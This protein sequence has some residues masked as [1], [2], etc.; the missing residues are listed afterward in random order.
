MILYREI[1]YNYHKIYA[2][3]ILDKFVEAIEGIDI[4]D[5]NDPNWNTKDFGFV[6]I[7]IYRNTKS[8]SSSEGIIH[9]TS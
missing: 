3:K 7:H 1:E 5:N 6:T 4:P 8:V 2:N 9:T